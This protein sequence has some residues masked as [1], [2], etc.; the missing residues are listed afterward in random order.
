MT[1]ATPPRHLGSLLTALLMAATLASAQTATP[2]SGVP[3]DVAR[4]RAE[5]LNDIPL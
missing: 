1:L 4:G 3:L 5:L 2:A